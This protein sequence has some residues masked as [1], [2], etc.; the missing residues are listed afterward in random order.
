[1]GTSEKKATKEEKKPKKDQ[2][3][4]RPGDTDA[5]EAAVRAA[6][7]L[8]KMKKKAREE[9]DAVPTTDVEPVTEGRP[10]QATAKKR[11]PP[12]V[13]GAGYVCKACDQPGHWVYD[14]PRKTKNKRRK[15]SGQPLDDEQRAK[16]R[17]PS[18]NDIAKARA[19]MPVI[20]MAD[21]PQCRCGLR[22]APRKNRAR[23]SPGEGLMFWWW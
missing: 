16:H 3:D 8:K 20:R 22:S 15:T 6:K 11:T 5:S 19:A 7:K 21:A 2:G 13:P 1:M 12:S 23:G 14:C 4:A 10:G 17:D 18:P 9:A